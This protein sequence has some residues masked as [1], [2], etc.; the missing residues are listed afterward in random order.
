[1]AEYR[2]GKYVD[3]EDHEVYEADGTRLTEARADEIVEEVSAEVRKPG[4]PSLTGRDQESPHISFRITPEI[5]KLAEE[6]AAREGTTVSQLARTIFEQSLSASRGAS[7][8]PSPPARSKPTGRDQ[9]SGG[10]FA[11]GIKGERS[12]AAP[13]S[14]MPPRWR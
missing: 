9:H 10:Y 5:K 2:A 1:M 8:S 11:P 3:L 14:A 4:R 12:A 6:R 7:T 13:S